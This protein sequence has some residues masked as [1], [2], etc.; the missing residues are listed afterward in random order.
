M[1]KLIQSYALFAAAVICFV[2]SGRLEGV[3]EGSIIAA[4]AIGNI[5]RLYN[6]AFDRLT[7]GNQNA[8]IP[9]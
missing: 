6:L 2:C 3:R 7:G 4:V 5:I 1:K 9:G 8:K